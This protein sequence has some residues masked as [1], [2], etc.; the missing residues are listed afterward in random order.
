MGANRPLLAQWMGELL[1]LRYFT[2]NNTGS[3]E[4]R[5]SAMSEDGVL[6]QLV[7]ADEDK[8]RFY[9]WSSVQRIQHPVDE[10]EPPR[11]ARAHSF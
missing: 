9:P 7:G 6:V 4:C 11:Q 10:P 3:L 8:T 5:L 1:E 2:G